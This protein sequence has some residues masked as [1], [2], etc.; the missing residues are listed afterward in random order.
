MESRVVSSCLT[1]SQFFTLDEYS[2]SKRSISVPT[3][4]DNPRHA[5]KRMLEDHKSVPMISS[6]TRLNIG[7]PMNKN[8]S[9][10]VDTNREETRS[11]V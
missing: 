3:V 9:T 2:S 7:R 4:V 8:Q 11:T 5:F 10:L 6:E 1:I